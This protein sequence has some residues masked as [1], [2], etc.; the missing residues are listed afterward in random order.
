MPISDERLL[1]ALQ[2]LKNG[3]L[4]VR[5]PEDETG[6]A[7]EI[8]TTFNEFI[9]QMSMLIGE[10]KRISHELGTEGR[11]GGQVEVEGLSGAWAEMSDGVNT[12]EYLLT[13]QFRT[14][15]LTVE[16]MI[17]EGRVKPLEK[18]Q[19]NNEIS[20]LRSSVARLALILSEKV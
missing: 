4:S 14:L 20:H 19:T 15:A 13:E 16:L 10:V 9:A 1:A 2:A 12:M 5:L 8:A 17:N 3:D 7:G 11:F 6:T 18:Y